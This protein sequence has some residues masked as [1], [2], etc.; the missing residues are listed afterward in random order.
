MEKKLLSS[1]RHRFSHRQYKQQINNLWV[2]IFNSQRL[3]VSNGQFQIQG[4]V[5]RTWRRRWDLFRL[6]ALFW[7]CLKRRSDTG[8]RTRKVSFRN[9]HLLVAYDSFSLICLDVRQIDAK[10]RC[11][12]LYPKSLHKQNSF[13][14]LVFNIKLDPNRISVAGK[15]VW[16]SQRWWWLFEGTSEQSGLSRICELKL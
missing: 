14:L 9:V 13:W 12:G 7:L 11:S 4:S 15:I 10:T 5:L 8:R 16:I 3:K 2:G 6:T 1:Y